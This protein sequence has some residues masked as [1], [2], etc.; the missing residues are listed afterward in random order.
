MDAMLALLADR[1]RVE[2]VRPFYQRALEAVGRGALKGAVV[3]VKALGYVPRA[4]VQVAGPVGAAAVATVGGGVA[5]YAGY[6]HIKRTRTSVQVD[7]LA[8]APE[9]LVP[10]SP[11]IR[12]GKIPSCQVSVGSIGPEGEIMLV[13]AGIRV[14]DYLITPTHN[15]HFGR[16]LVIFPDGR[17]EQRVELDPDSEI[18]LAADV[19]AF[20][21]PE[22]TWA[23]LAVARAKM[24]PVA[25]AV[26]VTV[27]SS[28]D[29]TYTVGS[30]KPNQT[31][32][33]RIFYD[34]STMPGYSGSAYMN[35]NTCVGMH[36]HGGVRAGGYEILYLWVRLKINNKEA[37]ESSEDF[38]RKLKGKRNLQVEELAD[39]VIMRTPTGH[40]HLTTKQ[41]YDRLETL[42][43]DDWA[44]EVERDEIERELDNRE[45][46]GYDE[47][48]GDYNLGRGRM[49][50]RATRRQAASVRAYRDFA[51][52][53]NNDDAAYIPESACF[54]G[55]SQRLVT[56][57]AC[58]D[59]RSQKDS[60]S[61]RSQS[62]PP[63]TKQQQQTRPSSGILDKRPGQLIPS[64]LKFM[65]QEKVSKKQLWRL[66]DAMGKQTPQ[67]EP[68]GTPS[69]SS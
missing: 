20:P 29:K 23:R 42:R 30:L 67:Q 50:R 45:E 48:Y 9:G 43:E 10:G 4:M 63:P 66:L 64:L 55:E 18:S 41:L 6:R 49:G 69:T 33:G 1:V 46:F 62:R 19:S 13:G 28:C 47:E 37:P 27:T 51:G 54:A 57:P 65:D 17:F 12:N 11:L 61:K 21:V 14:E 56:G 26:T 40:Y 7:P 58:R 36:S 24:G 32:I 68:S 25:T 44:D 53:G 15:C 31:A 5:V 22:Q 3:G 35:G 52:T 16:K 2:V 60:D 38:L 34:A 39:D 8:V 59:Y